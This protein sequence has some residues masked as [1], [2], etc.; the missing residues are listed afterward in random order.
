MGTENL[1]FDIYPGTKRDPTLA[2][3]TVRD[4]DSPGKASFRS[5]TWL[6]SLTLI[7]TTKLLE[8]SSSLDRERTQVER[9]KL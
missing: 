6:L 5:T 1:D 8:L 3:Y 9:V 4:S 2:A 7:T